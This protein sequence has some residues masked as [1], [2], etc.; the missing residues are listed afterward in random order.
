MLVLY[1]VLFLFC[2]ET[3]ELG[4]HRFFVTLV[5]ENDG[6]LAD[7]VVFFFFWGGGQVG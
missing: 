3:R 5:S 2:A 4:K 6:A 1:I 7:P